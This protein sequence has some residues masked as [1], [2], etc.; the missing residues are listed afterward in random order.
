MKFDQNQ[1]YIIDKYL[2]YNVVNI[3]SV[4]HV[5]VILLLFKAISRK[6]QTRINHT[7]TIWRP[8]RSNT[9]IATL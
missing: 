6:Q 4:G 1:I 8:S 9:T 5:V 2:H 7:H 3:A